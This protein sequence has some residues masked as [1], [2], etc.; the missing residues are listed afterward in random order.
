MRSRRERIGTAVFSAAWV[1]VL[2][3]ALRLGATARDV[4]P[5]QLL[6]L[7][8]AAYLGAWGLLFF[9]S[10]CGPAGDAARFAACTASLVAAVAA[11]ELPALLRAVDYRDVFATPTPPWRRSGN[12]P[13]PD[14]LYVRSGHRHVRRAFLGNEQPGRG[15]AGFPPTYRCDVRYD[16]NG[17][18]NPTD[19]PA[20]D[21]VVVGDS[22]VEGW[23]VAD[24][25]LLTARLAS[26]LG[27]PVANLG[28]NGDG[29]QQE[30]HVLRRYGLGLRPRTCV[31]AFYEGNDLAD[32]ARY[33]TSRKQAARVS[34]EGW[35]R[36]F[37]ARSFT[38]N[39]LAFAVRTCLRPEP[40]RS[41]RFVM[42]RFVDASG[43]RVPVYF[44]GEFSEGES[45]GIEEVRSVL[46]EA[47]EL[48]AR[49]GI[50]LV[51]AFIPTKLRV[52]EGLCPIDGSARPNGR[53]DDTPRT[54]ESLVRGVSGEI[55]FLDLT[56][57]LRAEAAAGVQVYLRD[58]EHWSADGHRAAASAIAEFVN[59]RRSATQA[60]GPGAAPE[61]PRPKSADR[62]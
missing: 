26:T 53:P 32:A 55:G 25:E 23:H 38:R 48:C 11:F 42:G 21:M 50:D 27:R 41:D 35:A 49:Q 54:V 60:A 58:D 17:F 16:R 13:D 7:L 15:W 12:R 61:R 34:R 37:Y 2:T 62:A 59:G 45:P 57:R 47:H 39:S 4:N 9:R 51:V 40:G 24:P 56:A 36:A 14:L 52:Y 44:G 46:A 22:F 20:A 28:R 29:P 19:L 1:L 33:E 3:L 5:E 30:L 43:G 31:W 10:R 6:G 8:A 18:R